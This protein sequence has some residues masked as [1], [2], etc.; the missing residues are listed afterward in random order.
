MKTEKMFAAKKQ[1][2]F[3]VNKKTSVV[4]PNENPFISRSLGESAKTLSGNG[5]TKY[6]TSGYSVG[7][8]FLDQFAT[9]SQYKAPR[10]F[11][12]ISKDMEFLWSLDPEMN[13]WPFGAGSLSTQ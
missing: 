2:L 4:N 1:N 5:A 12:E 13:H 10:N 7:S 11:S 9:I 8:K 6:S 3:D